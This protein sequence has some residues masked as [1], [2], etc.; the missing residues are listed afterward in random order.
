M[1][2]ASDVVLSWCNIHYI[3]VGHKSLLS[4]HVC[5]LCCLVPTLTAGSCLGDMS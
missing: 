2:V 1:G 5:V 4:M 3:D